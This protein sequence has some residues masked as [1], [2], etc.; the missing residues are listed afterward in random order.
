MPLAMIVTSNVQDRY[1]GFLTSVM[2]EIAP[3]TY[4]SP[5]M[6]AGVR[7]RVWS[8]MESWWE[9]LQTGSLVLVWA[10]RQAPGGLRIETLG[11]PKKTI[12]DADGVLL[13][14]RE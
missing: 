6:S 9:V 10:D 12:V 14:K 2:L 5:R 4:V 8:V 7:T 11:L 13:V 3:G 1:R